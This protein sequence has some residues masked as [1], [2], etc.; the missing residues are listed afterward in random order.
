MHE[1]NSSPTT[2]QRK[3]RINVDQ[4]DERALDTIVLPSNIN[5]GADSIQ[6][7][8]L[9]HRDGEKNHKKPASPTGRTNSHRASGANPLDQSPGMHITQVKAGPG[10]QVPDTNDNA[11]VDGNLNK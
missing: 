5:G 1:N 8:T 11:N 9:S 7:Q 6:K 3:P 4:I 2:D 10:Q